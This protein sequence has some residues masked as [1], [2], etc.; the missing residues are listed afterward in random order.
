MK[1]CKI[2]PYLFEGYLII[3]LHTDWIKTFDGIPDFIVNIEK[4]QKLHIIS[5]KKV[6]TMGIDYERDE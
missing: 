4:G 3:S 1:K 5:D 2:T 6:K